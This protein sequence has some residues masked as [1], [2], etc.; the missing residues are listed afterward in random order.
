M[1]EAQDRMRKMQLSREEA[2]FRVREKSKE[3]I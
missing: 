2:V 3:L 1:A